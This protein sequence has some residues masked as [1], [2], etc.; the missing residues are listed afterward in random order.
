MKLRKFRVRT[1]LDFDPEV[2]TV[3]MRSMNMEMLG[4]AAFKKFEVD[5][6]IRVSDFDCP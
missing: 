1:A 6:H 4:R 2:D 3:V 5:V